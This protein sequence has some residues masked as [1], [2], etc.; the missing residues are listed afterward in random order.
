MK[1]YIYTQNSEQ[2]E[3]K[4]K[5]RKNNN[6]KHENNMNTRLSQKSEF[7]KQQKWKIMCY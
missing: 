1:Q 6:D 2:M 4:T 5:N 7:S 3:D